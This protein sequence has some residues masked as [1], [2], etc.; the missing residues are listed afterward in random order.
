MREE[1]DTPAFW[2][3]YEAALASPSST[4]QKVTAGSLAAALEMYRKSS[5][6]AQ[7]SN[8]TRRQREFVYRA[9]SESAGS[10]VLSDISAREIVA[11]RERRAATPHR[12]NDYIK[13][14]RA[15]FGWAAGDGG[16]IPSDPTVGVKLLKGRNDDIGFHTWTE[17]ECERFEERWPLGSMERLAFDL[18]L[19]TGLRRGDACRLG[20]EHLHDGVL[21]IRMEKTRGVVHLPLL[22]PLGASIAATQCAGRT[23]IATSRGEPFVKESFGN[24]FKR[25]CVSAG[26]PGSCH[27]LRKAGAT[28]AAEAGATEHELMAFFGW[29]N[30]K[31]AAV[32]TRAASRQK[33]AAA[34]AM[35]LL[36][37][38][39]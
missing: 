8:A 15:F 23:F 29:Q 11:G 32:Y 16:L 33:L 25:A 2:A 39:L 19:Y 4:T 3:E 6:W 13:A 34:A 30:S 20:P 26:V 10:V 31:Q 9:L 18:M 38:R 35:R 24:W 28:R 21:S 5:A 14:M 37:A 1:H 22:A 27:G 17:A 12:A 36:P 7:L